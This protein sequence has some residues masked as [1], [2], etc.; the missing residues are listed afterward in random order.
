MVASE[1]SCFTDRPYSAVS[2]QASH[3][4]YPALGVCLSNAKIGFSRTKNQQVAVPKSLK[5]AILR[6]A[7][8]PTA[9]LRV[10]VAY[11]RSIPIAPSQRVG[12][13]WGQTSF[14]G[15]AG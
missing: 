11:E 5:S 2:P 15:Q 12:L 10:E 3:R 6:H 14:W 9:E 4:A 8:R 7:P 13:N 1:G